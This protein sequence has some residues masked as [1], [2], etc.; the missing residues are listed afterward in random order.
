MNVLE[1]FAFFLGDSL[2]LSYLCMTSM[3]LIQKMHS[4]SLPRL[5]FTE[6]P[7]A[8]KANATLIG[9]NEWASHLLIEEDMA[10][11]FHSM[12][13]NLGL[14]SKVSP[15]LRT[16]TSYEKFALQLNST[17]IWSNLRQWTPHL[18]YYLNQRNPLF[19]KCIEAHNPWRLSRKLQ[20][21]FWWNQPSKEHHL[22][23]SSIIFTC[24]EWD[25]FM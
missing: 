21:P 2:S 19:E 9:E 20:C 7:K 23:G 16:V 6:C 18:C 22:Q 17:T 4:Y 11:N 10:L 12:S 8:F 1:R 15:K 24:H 25:C 13:R 3:Y 5:L 14:S